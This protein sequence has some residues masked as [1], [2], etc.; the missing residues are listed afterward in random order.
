MT[1]IPV[2][3]LNREFKLRMAE[4]RH[5]TGEVLDVASA[6]MTLD[7]LRGEAVLRVTF[8]DGP[9]WLVPLGAE[10]NRIIDTFTPSRLH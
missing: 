8:P 3:T 9:T 6:A 10:A 2:D 7:W 1:K 5:L 4:H